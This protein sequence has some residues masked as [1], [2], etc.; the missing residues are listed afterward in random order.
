MYISIVFIVMFFLALVMLP[1]FVNAIKYYALTPVV[2]LIYFFIN[3][4]VIKRSNISTRASKILCLSFYTLLFICVIMMD[5]VAYPK[6][7][8]LW[9]PFFLIAFPMVYIDRIYMTSSYETFYLVVYA[10]IAKSFEPANVF[11]VDMYRSI[12]AYLIA[13]F[14]DRLIIDMRCNEGL[15]KIQLSEMIS[16]D[17]LTHT[18][19]K[20]T[21][22]KKVN[23]WLKNND[24]RQNYALCIIDVDDFKKV[25]DN[26]GHDVGDQV[27]KHI[28]N[29]LA[30]NVPSG[31]IVGRYGGDE[32]VLFIPDAKSLELTAFKLRNL[33]MFLTDFSIEGSSNFTVSIGAAFDSYG[34]KLEDLFKVADDALYT[35]KLS[36]KNMS[37]VWNTHRL[38]MPQKPVV[39]YLT[40]DDNDIT[41][42]INDAFCDIYDICNMESGNA[43]PYLCQIYASIVMIIMDFDEKNSDDIL[44]LKYLRRRDKFNHIHIKTIAAGESSAATS[45][46]Y[47]IKPIFKKDLN[48]EMLTQIKL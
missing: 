17:T 48:K 2:L 26:L 41:S 43:L 30:M 47:G 9:F 37:T 40:H 4:A 27:L 20:G 1:T 3:L 46:E 12:A 39:M 13:L 11:S 21:F 8:S 28:G 29:L 35:S 25:N 22:Y 23:E 42:L 5:I 36:G 45:K 10:I 7:A 44:L 16:F 38:E 6:K 14:L 19:N 33:Q 32:F 34:S 24:S 15:A 31:D 18:H